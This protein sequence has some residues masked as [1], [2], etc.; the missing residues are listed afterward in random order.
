MKIIDARSGEILSVGST[1]RYHGGEWTRLEAVTP[2]LF[3][4][5]A[6][7]VSHHRDYSKPGDPFVTKQMKVPLRVRWMHPGFPF[8]HVG[9]LPS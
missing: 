4:A 7:I 1:V 2:G 6:V 3:S 9:F 5:S 8:Q